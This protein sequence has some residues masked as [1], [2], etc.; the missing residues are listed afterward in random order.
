MLRPNKR[1]VTLIEMLVVVTIIALFVSIAGI[2][3]FNRLGEIK[4]TAAAV[5]IDDFIGALA[6]YK[7]ATGSFPTSEQGLAA[8]RRDPGDVPGWSGP[9]LMKE[10]PLDPWKRPYIYRYPG[11]VSP[12]PEVVRF[13]ADGKPGGT[14]ED[15][16]AVS[17][18]VN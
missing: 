4:R 14:G 9:Y 6:Q 8:L 3:Y 1:G 13:G 7:L 12:D 18:R 10:I 11:E 17:W 15:A 16:G 2:R 5:Q